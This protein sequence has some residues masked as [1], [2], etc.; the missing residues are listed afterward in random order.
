MNMSRTKR[1]GVAAFI[2]I[3]LL[4]ASPAFAVDMYM[5][6]PAVVAKSYG[7]NGA[8]AVSD[9][10]ADSRE[11]YANYHRKYTQNLELRNSNGNGTT[12]TSALDTS[13]PVTNLQ[14]CVAVNFYPDSCTGWWK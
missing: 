10:K 5:S 7:T 8:I 12:V 4:G 13:N 11:V 14:A 9:V 1:L 3:T 2:G 6:N